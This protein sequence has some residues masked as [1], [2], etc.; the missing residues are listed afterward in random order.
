M[1]KHYCRVCLGF[2]ENTKLGGQ[3]CFRAVSSLDRGLLSAELCSKECNA[4]ERRAQTARH[5]R[6][7]SVNGPR[8]DGPPV[9]TARAI[10]RK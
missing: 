10:L 4:Q 6:G 8:G 2:S 1:E 3:I 7:R 5:E 9:Q